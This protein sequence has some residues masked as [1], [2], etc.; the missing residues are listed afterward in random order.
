MASLDVSDIELARRLDV[1]RQ[2][3]YNRRTGRTPMTA[4]DIARMAQALEVEPAILLGAP[5]KALQWLVDNRSAELDEPKEPDEGDELS[6]YRRRSRCSVLPASRLTLPHLHGIL[7]GP[8]K[9]EEGE[10][11]P[12]EY[13]CGTVASGTAQQLPTVRGLWQ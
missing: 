8:R 13:L 1:S 3:I 11:A 9:L 2:T 7:S 6:K 12:P 5:H 10:T 4:D